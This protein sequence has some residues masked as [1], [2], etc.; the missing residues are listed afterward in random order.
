MQPTHRL[1]EQ[2][3]TAVLVEG[4]LDLLTEV[5]AEDVTVTDV[6][7]D[8]VIVGRTAYRDHVELL[9]TAFSSL[10][11][12]YEVIGNADGVLTVEY[13]VTGIHDG[14]F[15]GIAPTG[16]DITIRGIDVITVD[17]DRIT[18]IKTV[19]DLFGLLTD[20]GAISPP[21]GNG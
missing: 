7:F 9:R 14:P 12:E 10:D 16:N 3:Y 19:F 6:A 4:D 8:G 11:A 15:L 20:I 2:L 5:V 13:V 17:Q 21:T 18:A 1:V